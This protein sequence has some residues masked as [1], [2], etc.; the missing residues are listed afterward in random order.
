MKNNLVWV[1][2]PDGK[3]GFLGKTPEQIAEEDRKFR[4]ENQ[5][6]SHKVAVKKRG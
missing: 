3:G 1:T 6:K 5:T 2:W 4:E